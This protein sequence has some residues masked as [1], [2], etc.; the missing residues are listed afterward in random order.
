[1]T[2]AASSQHHVTAE[3]SRTLRDL[4]EE[5]ILTVVERALKSY[6][7]DV[8]RATLTALHD[9]PALIASADPL[10]DGDLPSL[11]AQAGRWTSEVDA[12][13]LVGIEQEFQRIYSAYTA[14]DEVMDSAALAAMQAYLGKVRDR[15]VQ[16]TYAGVTVYEESFDLVRTTLVKAVSL[17]WSTQ[18]TARRIAAV[19]D[20]DLDASYWEDQKAAATG[21]I[22]S[23][24]DAIGA[25]GSPARE[26]ARLNDP[27]V[28]A[29]QQD[30]SLATQRLDAAETVWGIRARLIARTEATGVAN[31]GARQALIT[32]GWTHKKW[33]AT[34]DQR[35]RPDHAAA[36]GQVVKVDAEFTVGGFSMQHPGDPGAPVSETAN[37]RCTIIGADR[38]D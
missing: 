7:A 17:G 9:R 30:S 37:C 16:G 28:N 26:Y 14:N 31:F 29:L 1:M 21:E 8:K 12:S 24:L 34:H 5:S 4:T 20:W 18:Q 27:R 13:V 19:L 15:L 22:D 36:D 3:A 11:G 25:P 6:I 10:P 32:E 35:T 33:V 2:A 38:K 23:I